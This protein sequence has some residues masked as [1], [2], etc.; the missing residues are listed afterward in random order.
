MDITSDELKVVNEVVTQLICQNAHSA[1]KIIDAKT[2][3]R[4]TRE[5]FGGR[6]DRR[7][8]K[9]V[10][11]TFGRPNF[12]TRQYIKACRK[13]DEPFPVKKVW[14]KFPPKKRKKK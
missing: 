12:A 11:L 6:I 7:Y 9:K 8:C 4:A 3:V 2:V 1:T 14:L 10:V 5:L 13:A